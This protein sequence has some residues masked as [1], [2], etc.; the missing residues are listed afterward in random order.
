MNV[1]VGDKKVSASTIRDGDKYYIRQSFD[2]DQEVIQLDIEAD[3]LVKAKTAVASYGKKQAREF[4]KYYE[5][6]PEEFKEI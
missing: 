1:Q 3:S 4:L 2:G 6:N 5:N